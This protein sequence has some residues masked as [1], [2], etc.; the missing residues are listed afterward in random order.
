MPETNFPKERFLQRVFIFSGTGNNLI[1]D[2][3]F[4]ENVAHLEFFYPAFALGD[5]AAEVVLDR[6]DLQQS[7]KL[8][9][10]E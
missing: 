10:G 4:L 1:N 2:K 7:V 5:I 8:T 6:K 9:L 3:G